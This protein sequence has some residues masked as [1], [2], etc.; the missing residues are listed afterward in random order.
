M[1][2][3]IQYHTDF[4]APPS[5][6]AALTVESENDTDLKVL[7]QIRDILKSY[8]LIASTT[9]RPEFLVKGNNT[10]DDTEIGT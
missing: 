3:Y 9:T 4:N 5:R 6:Y 7:E 2:A 1:R 10:D 8:G